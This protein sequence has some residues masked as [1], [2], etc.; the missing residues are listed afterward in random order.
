MQDSVYCAR[1]EH[2]IRALKNGDASDNTNVQEAIELLQQS[3]QPPIHENNSMSDL[4]TKETLHV[5]RDERE[6]S[7]A[8]QEQN[9]DFA[10]IELMNAVSKYKC[11]SRMITLVAWFAGELPHDLINPLMRQKLHDSVD[12]NANFTERKAQFEALQHQHNLEDWEHLVNPG[13]AGNARI[14]CFDVAQMLPR[15][16]GFDIEHVIETARKDDKHSKM[17]L[18]FFCAVTA[19]R[20]RTNSVLAAQ[21]YKT[22]NEQ[23][24]VMVALRDSCRRLTN[25]S[26]DGSKIIYNVR[27][28]PRNLAELRNG[29]TDSIE[30]VLRYPCLN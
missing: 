17:F 8:A 27:H 28:P 4:L 3:M 20:W 2:V 1:K 14:A 26:F 10:Y 22:K 24:A 23:E 7:L 30:W 16:H 9:N 18:D 25:F 21:P 29:S 15:M 19:A 11:I 5:L 13:L 6:R 12:L